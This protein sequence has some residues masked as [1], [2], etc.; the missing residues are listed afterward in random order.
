MHLCEVGWG[1]PGGC[2]DTAYCDS[3]NQPM[4]G[5]WTWVDDEDEAP[6]P[7]PG[8]EP[9]HIPWALEGGAP[10]AAAAVLYA[11][12]GWYVVPV[13]ASNP[14]HAGSLLG[15]GWPERTSND[16]DKVARWFA[17]AEAKFRGIE[18]GVVLHVGR[19]GAIAFDVDHPERMPDVL[20]RAIDEYNP[21]FQSSRTNV[22][23]RGSYVFA[24]PEGVMFGSSAGSL[25]KDWGEVK[26][27]NGCI[28]V[29]PTPHPKEALGGRY[30]W[31]RTGELPVLPQALGA[32]LLSAPTNKSRQYPRPSKLNARSRV[33]G[34]LNRLLKANEGERNNLL[35]WTACR[36]GELVAAGV[37]DEGD[38]TDLLERAAEQLGLPAIE[39][40]GTVASGIRTGQWAE[41]R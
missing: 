13:D 16:V 5:G 20:R 37:I 1:P 7:E 38:A 18:V 21:P 39:A 29:A 36:F 9:L 33:R 34:L 41:A 31:Q 35:H 23:G 10:M 4:C 12:A 19:S 32:A 8:T 14:R 30:A 6:A 15:N 2:P 3:R 22:P 24:L 11:A 40:S 27:R 26:G 25:G 28:T 17:S